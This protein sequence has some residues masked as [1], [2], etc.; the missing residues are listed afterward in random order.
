[1]S[2]GLGL[3][4]VKV[5]S[6]VPFTWI[7]LGLNDLAMVGGTIVVSDAVADAP[8]PVFVPLSV[9]ERKP[10]TLVCGPAVVAVTLTLTVHDPLAGMVPPVVCP[11]ASDV[12]A[13]T[14]AH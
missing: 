9:V 4:I 5:S 10:L 3:V 6:D 7:G 2:L 8:A 1:M 11:K 12:D 13:A 14:G